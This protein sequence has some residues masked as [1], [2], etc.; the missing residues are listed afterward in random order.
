MPLASLAR[1]E[2]ARLI[3]PPPSVK[4][5]DVPLGCVA[6][7]RLVGNDNAPPRFSGAVP[8][9]MT[10]LDGLRAIGRLM[11]CAL[12]DSLTIS[13]RCVIPVPP[14]EVGTVSQLRVIALPLSVYA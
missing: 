14:A 11:A 2:P 9:A 1:P 3:P 6:E 5:S 8:V 10:C 13:P 4:M 7:P 12:A